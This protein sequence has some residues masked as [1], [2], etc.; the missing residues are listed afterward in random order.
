MISLRVFR[1]GEGPVAM[2]QYARSLLDRGQHAF[3]CP[4]VAKQDSK[5]CGAV[6]PW[7][8]VRHVA[9]LSFEEMQL[10]EK[11]ISN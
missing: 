6:W 2:S 9:A 11:M 1:F 8:M 4:Q 3:P 10:F 5:R 7:F